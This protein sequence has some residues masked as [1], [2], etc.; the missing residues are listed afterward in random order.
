MT[1]L[2]PADRSRVVLIGSGSYRHLSDLPAVANNLTDLA[3]A[4]RAPARWGIPAKNCTVVPDGSSP[5]DVIDAVRRAAADVGR[6]GLLLI[7]YAG[8][9]LIDADNGRL[10]LAVTDS[11][12]GE[13]DATAV[14]YESIRRR[15]WQS[16]A[17][18]KLVI[19]DCCYAGRAMIGE[20]AGAGLGED[21]E[22]DQSVIIAATSRNLVALAPPGQ[23]HTAF[24]GAL[25][26]ILNEGIVNGPPVLDSRTIWREVLRVQVAKGR[27]RPEFRS[28]N[29]ADDI[30]LV[31]N[32]WPPPA[33]VSAPPPARRRGSWYWPAGVLAGVAAL[34]LV[35]VPKW[36]AG[37]SDDRAAG[38]TTAASASVVPSRVSPTPT[39]AQPSMLDR[40]PA[41]GVCADQEMSV[42]PQAASAT[43]HSGATLQLTLTVKNV[44]LR[45]CTRDVGAGA[46]E[47][48]IDQGAKKY[49]SS[50]ACSTDESSDNRP[51][52][53]G[54]QRVYKV[55]WSGRQSSSCAGNAAS[56]PALPPGRF[57]LRA[58]LNTLVSAPVTI[59]VVA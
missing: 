10:H 15:V 50:D 40:N 27:P 36:P 55:T 57:E 17:G 47:I 16:R 22:I 3:A 20:M 59:T 23:R 39:E 31:R 52:G 43:V 12:R 29:A 51:F 4:L 7:Y 30:P 44:G 8:H 28:R 38:P 14:A 37:G 49:W 9:G 21:V 53:P 26:T 33:T 46:Q 45:A 56:G 19:L 54:E 2:P 13:E 24:T 18:A 11:E 42:V 41:T 1:G 32:A 35:L 34:G 48:Y 6:D 25:L 5:R 58:R